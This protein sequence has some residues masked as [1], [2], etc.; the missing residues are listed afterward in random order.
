MVT[1]KALLRIRK[2]IGQIADIMSPNEENVQSILNWIIPDIDP[3]DLKRS[4]MAYY[5]YLETARV[6]NDQVVYDEQWK[7]YF[8]PLPSLFAKYS[9]LTTHMKTTIKVGRNWWPYIQKYVSNPNYILQRV[10]EKNKQISDMLSTELGAKFIQYYTERLYTFFEIYFWKFPRY[11]NNCGG[12]ILYRLVNKQSNSWGFQCRRCKAAF[13]I[14][15]IDKMTYQKRIYS[16][17]TIKK[18]DV[19]SQNP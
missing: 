5:K 2:S 18:N 11:H 10:S 17:M 4:L 14:D 3:N 13:S 6:V 16:E 8:D 15:D 19:R 7:R 12:L 9:F 1:K